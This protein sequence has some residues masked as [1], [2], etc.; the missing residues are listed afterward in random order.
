MEKANFV[1]D[2][3][4]YNGTVYNRSWLITFEAARGTEAFGICAGNPRV[5]L[6]AFLRKQRPFFWGRG[7]ARRY[8]SERWHDSAM[9]PDRAPNPMRTRGNFFIPQEGL[10]VRSLPLFSE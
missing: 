10:G 7:S 2:D 9:K 8:L 3:G 5:F 6:S 1:F 4:P